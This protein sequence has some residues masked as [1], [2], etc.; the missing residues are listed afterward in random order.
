MIKM[1]RPIGI[2]DSG[3]GGLTVF[4]EIRKKLPEKDIIYFGDTA[5]VPYGSKSKNTI[6]QY[7]LQNA[8]FL[9]R[10]NIKILVVACNTSSAYAIDELKK[11]FH[12]PI[13]GVIE[14]GAIKALEMTRN[15]RI[16]IIGTYGTIKSRSYEKSLKAL[17]KDCYIFSK[18]TPLLVPLVEENW[19][20]HKVSKMI[21]E[22]YLAELI[23]QKIDTLILGCT[24]YPVLKKVIKEV[25]GKD[26][27]LVDSAESVAQKIQQF[28]SEESSEGKIG[29]NTFYISDNPEKFKLSGKQILKQ[30]LKNVHKVYFSDAWIVDNFEKQI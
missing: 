2:F 8:A 11:H 27:Q 1:N 7:S 15:K 22:E 9:I 21:I 13:I 16:G 19:I 6:I 23:E 17:S 28:F 10:Q 26:V 24:H 20:D 4:R 5:R 14:P 25:V 29:N 12:I 3:V 30:D 18:A